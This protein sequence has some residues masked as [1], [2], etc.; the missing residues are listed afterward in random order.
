MPPAPAGATAAAPLLSTQLCLCASPPCRTWRR[1][2]SALPLITPAWAASGRCA[3][4]APTARCAARWARACTAA[5][6]GAHPARLCQAP[7]RS[8]SRCRGQARAPPAARLAHPTLQVDVEYGFA[9][10]TPKGSLAARDGGDGGAVAAAA[11]A[12]AVVFSVPPSARPQG[13]SRCAPV[14]TCRLAGWTCVTV[15]WSVLSVPADTCAC[16]PPTFCKLEP[17]EAPPRLPAGWQQQASSA[18]SPMP[19]QQR[20]QRRWRRPRCW[21]S[22]TPRAAA[23]VANPQAAAAASGERSTCQSAATSAKPRPAAHALDP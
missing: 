22:R 5:G 11:A 19:R 23:A 17:H 10:I 12:A 20:R 9:P 3:T 8:P 7:A 4:T 18:R 1:S 16:L 13:G 2:R 14:N 6:E 15:T 21:M